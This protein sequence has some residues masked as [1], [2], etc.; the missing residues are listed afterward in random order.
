VQNGKILVVG[1]TGR[2]GGA[3]VENL[4]EEGF[5]VRALVRQ[6]EKGERLSAMGAELAV[7]DATTPATLEDAVRGC[8]SIF[9]AL[10][11]GPDRGASEDVEY[12]GN[13]NLLSAARSAGVG[14]F[15]YSSVRLA[16]HPQAQKVG[17][18]REKARFE[19]E[20]LD[21][22][23]V[24]STILLRPAILMETLDIMIQ[25]P[26]AFV[27]GRQRRP[28]SLIAAR[29]IARAA[30]RAIQRDILGRYELAGPET[31]TFDEAFH[32]LG[33]ARGKKIRTLHVPLVTLHAAGRFSPTSARWRT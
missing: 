29:D 25:G 7:G 9:S 21:A 33:K 1:A 6:P 28:V 5:E 17:A 27:P 26:V 20:L 24:S 22:E 15:V 10:A 12:R 18:F 3:A 14:H 16:D 2:V 23:N 32:R 19:K 11:A 30:V 13:M 31:V 4:L 8:S